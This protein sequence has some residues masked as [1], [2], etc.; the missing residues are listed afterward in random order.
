[1]ADKSKLFVREASGLVRAVGTFNATFFNLASLSG[2]VVLWA[3]LFLSLFS[4]AAI[5]GVAPLA[6]GHLIAGVSLFIMAFIFVILVMV[7][8]RS[9]GDYVF[10]SRIVHPLVGWLETWML[11]WTNLAIIAFELTSINLSTQAFLGAMGAVN[12]SSSWSAASGWI[13]VS[14]NQLI[15]GSIITIL[16]ALISIMSPK[17]FYAVI[18]SFCI[19]AVIAA[20]TMTAGTFT[21]DP[22]VFASN[23]QTYAGTKVQDIINAANSTGITYGATTFPLF[24]SM[25]AF[26]LFNL[27]GFQYSGYIAGELKGN[28]KRTSAVAMIGSVCI[29]LVFIWVLLNGS[30]VSRFGYELTNSWG[31]LY[32]NNPSAAPLGGIPPTNAVYGIIGRP[33]LWFVWLFVTVGGCLLMFALCPAYLVVM[34]R[35]LYAWSMDR[36]APAWFSKVN[37]R[38]ATPVRAYLLLAFGGWVFFVF[39]VYGLSLLSLAWYSVLL[40]A[41]TWIMPGINS[42]L[43]PFR[44]KDLYESSPWKKAAG[45]PIPAILGVVWL[46]II[47]PVYSIAYFSPII[48]SIASTPTTQLWTYSVSSGISLTVFLTILGIAI[49]LV[50]RWYNKRRG[51]DVELIFKTVPPE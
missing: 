6:W 17:K 47:I 31:Y 7:M 23:L 34:S 4:G 50:S 49:F 20:V 30:M 19:I 39:S 29:Y 12:P 36:V 40:S 28:L 45:V 14:T 24:A 44:R 21:I 15:Y 3:P 9:R 48:T 51:I 46:L 11:V 5:L 8:P 10:T 18:S 1:M 26:G 22:N 2:N 35:F 25:F 33:D 38:T 42:L 37:E 32:W 41:L 16:I 27:I 13:S 43:L